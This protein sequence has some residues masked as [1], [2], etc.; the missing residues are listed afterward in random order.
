[1]AGIEFWHRPLVDTMHCG[2]WD[3]EEFLSCLDLSRQLKTN[4][5]GDPRQELCDSSRF[6]RYV[7]FSAY[8]AKSINSA[9]GAFEYL[10]VLYYST[11]VSGTI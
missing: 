5:A 4:Y 8:S 10:Y 9:V 2:L 1:V 11:A 6:A 3:G 7:A